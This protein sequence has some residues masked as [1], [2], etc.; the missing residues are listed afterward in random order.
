MHSELERLMKCD[1]R[2]KPAMASLHRNLKDIHDR[3]VIEEALRNDLKT[4]WDN[5]SS[6]RNLTINVQFCRQRPTAPLMIMPPGAAVGPVV[7]APPPAWT[8]PDAYFVSLP[9]LPTPDELRQCV[10]KPSL[11]ASASS[12]PP[13]P[14]DDM[15]DQ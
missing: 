13:R 8:T 2:L 14:P 10:M 9:N 6:K 1:E 15:T 5:H 12:E 3:E 11:G 4:V 7:G